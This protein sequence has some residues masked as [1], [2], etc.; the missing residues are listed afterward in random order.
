[1]A[2]SAETE[3]G[4]FDA[5]QVGHVDFQSSPWPFISASAKDLIKKM[6]TTNPKKRITAAEA[7]GNYRKAFGLL[8]LVGTLS[9]IVKI[10]STIL[11]IQIKQF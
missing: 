8:S 9:F 7:L 6:L 2:C 11:R 1:M 5:I 4:I 10:M 3:K